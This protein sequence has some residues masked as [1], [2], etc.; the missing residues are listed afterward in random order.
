VLP[1]VPFGV[2]APVALALVV[3][4]SQPEFRYHQEW[5]SLKIE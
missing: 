5:A 1:S 3:H 2:L 4:A